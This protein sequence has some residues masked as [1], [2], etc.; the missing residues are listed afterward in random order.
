MNQI[1]EFEEKWV[2]SNVIDS[3]IVSTI[4]AI[5]IRVSRVDF[6][7]LI[8]QIYKIWGKMIIC[9]VMLWNIL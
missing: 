9:I 4:L 6:K 7:I 1:Y 5:D 8:D 3:F 2:S